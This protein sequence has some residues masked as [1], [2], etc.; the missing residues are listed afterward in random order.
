VSIVSGVTGNRVCV[1]LKGGNLDIEWDGKDGNVY[2][3]GPAAHVFDG[4]I[5]LDDILE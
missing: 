4:I 3:T 1:N 5:E 2:M